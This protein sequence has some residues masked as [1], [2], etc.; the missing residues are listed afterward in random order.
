MTAK[1][2]KW[3]LFLAIV[4]IVFGYYLYASAPT[5]S[6]WDCSE[7][8][9]TG[10]SLGI[11]HPPSTPLFV[12]L[13]RLVSFIPLRK[14]I[15]GRITLISGMFGAAC[16]GMI[17]LLV[18]YLVG[19]QGVPARKKPG[20]G[21]GTR[22]GAAP[23]DRLKVAVVAP[24]VASAPLTEPG[25]K[26]ERIDWAPHL[27]GFV[28]ALLCAFAYS[29]MFNT[30]EAIIF[31]PSATIAIAATLI[32][33]L[34]YIKEGKHAGD[35]RMVIA[36]IYLLVLATGVHFTPMIIF[37]ALLPFFLVVDRR[38][39][40]D[41]RLIELLGFFII[42]L[43]IGVV[44]GIAA[45]LLWGVLLGAAFYFAMRLLEGA[46]RDRQVLWAMLLFVGMFLLA[47][48][49]GMSVE[50]KVE[51][52]RNL[53]MDNIVMFLASP[54]AGILDRL[55]T[56]NALAL[57]VWNGKAPA[58]GN[59]AGLFFDQNV[60]L[61]VLMVL[62]YAGYLYYL[63]TKK[64]L[65]TKYALIG[66]GLFLLA[67]TVQFFLIV[68]AHQHPHINEVDPSTWKAF[69][70]SLR[71]EQ[72]NAMRL[73]P[74][75]TQYLLE[76]EY[77]QH[78]N[79]PPNYGLIPAYFEQLKYYLRYFLWQW[80]GRFNLDFFLT[81][82]TIFLQPVKFF[83]ALVG[84]I[85][86]LLGI[87]GIRDHWKRERKTAVLVLVAFL[88][89]SWGLLTYLNNKFS[90]SDP[91]G[92]ETQRIYKQEMYREVRERDYFYTFSFIY[93]T[94]FVGLGLNAFFRWLRT[95]ARSW[96]KG[97]ERKARLPVYGAGVAAVILPFLVMSF[98]FAEVNRRGNWIPNE[99]G[100][101]VLVSCENGGVIFTN[102]DNDTFP[103]WCAQ[104]VP[105]DVSAVAAAQERSHPDYPKKAQP[106]TLEP[107]RYGFRTQIAPGWGVAVANLSLLNTDWYCKQLKRWGA[108][109]SLTNE[110]I[111]ILAREGLSRDTREGQR[112]FIL[113]Q[114][115]I[116]D[117]VATNTGIKLRWPDEYTVSSEE[118]IKRVFKD[119][120]GKTPIYFATTVSPDNLRDVQGHLLQKGLAKLVVGQYLPEG[121]DFDGP[122]TIDLMFNKMN[123]KSSMDR[124]VTKDENTK[125]LLINYAVTFLDLAQY[126]DSVRDTVNGIRACESALRL[127]LESEKRAQLMYLLSHLL[128]RF[129][130]TASAAA[131]T[132]S[133]NVLMGADTSLNA[134]AKPKADQEQ[135][136]R[137]M[138]ARF[139]T[140]WTQANI[141][142][143]EGK[144]SEAEAVYQN[145]VGLLPD[146]HWELFDL[147]ST[148]M[149]DKVKAA[150][151]LEQ[152]YRKAGA[153]W[154][155]TRR[156]A[157]AF[158]GK[159]HERQR[160]SQVLDTWVKNNPR[161]SQKVRLVRDSL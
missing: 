108:P 66:L 97:Q 84:L 37:F 51:G 23:P 140:L 49:A 5:N 145:L 109:V 107:I 88:V 50:S 2:L 146:M 149:N 137:D 19:L 63:H 156:L 83:P 59:I 69:A 118:F 81:S 56:N 133:A 119:Y 4:A 76:N 95:E 150:A 134:T 9:A 113:S 87:W 82:K 68:R 104:E 98:N 99:Y 30:V 129:G 117:L 96:F 64:R 159:L 131:R 102:G 41:L 72:Y 143:A 34:W 32:G 55:F 148:A 8:V 45:K 132:D 114:V 57:W 21:P 47:Y 127:D 28:A 151:T 100:F 11:P 13:A 42:T 16:C 58:G 93:Y 135:Q 14:D 92:A 106:A 1:R 161:D 6:F 54:V 70:S 154:D 79:Y 101:N 77:Q 94:I 38:S 138:T 126:C 80:A 121:R 17:Y 115:M 29:F 130:Q 10:Y 24:P 75:Q 48:I 36:C 85:P 142:R 67:G 65:D 73:F 116:R 91:R 144:Y 52:G 26:T 39:V 12:Q 157:Q 3:I 158:A 71:R 44:P 86:P 33:V 40:I 111:E 123:M 31:T 15:G 136:R 46:T 110:Q 105:S 153:N 160:A 53:V 78:R 120:Q 60:V 61:F 7:F 74:R 155:N 141:L 18:V 25:V 122:A 27:A 139:Q 112:H 20:P 152:W 89:A 124:A 62:G 22:P 147:Y 90:T 128:A 43:T 35:N 103:L 125:G